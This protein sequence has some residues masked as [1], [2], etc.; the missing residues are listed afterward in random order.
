MAFVWRAESFVRVPVVHVSIIHTSK[1]TVALL[2][3]IAKVCCRLLQLHP[4]RDS[5]QLGVN[6]YASSKHGMTP[7]DRESGTGNVVISRCKYS[8][9][10]FLR[11]RQ[12]AECTSLQPRQDDSSSTCPWTKT[13]LLTKRVYVLAANVLSVLVFVRTESLLPRRTRFLMPSRVRVFSR[14]PPVLS[15]VTPPF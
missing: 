10:V 7:I 14:L 1:Y 3:K 9:T 12:G 8:N 13:Y 6:R 5:Q 4:L 15:A 2:F 11:N